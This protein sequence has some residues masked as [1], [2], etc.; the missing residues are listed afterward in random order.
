MNQLMKNLRLPV[1][2]LVASTG[3][4]VGGVDAAKVEETFG[5]KNQSGVQASFPD[6]IVQVRID[7]SSGMLTDNVDGS[8][9]M[10]YFEKG[11]EPTEYSGSFLEDSIYSSGG[12]A[13]E[14]LF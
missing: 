8:S 10:E 13:T 11:T 6:N 3:L 14:E 4:N 5:P 12:G 2:G 1:V 7:R 9:M